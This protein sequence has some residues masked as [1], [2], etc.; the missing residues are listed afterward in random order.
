MDINH[1]LLEFAKIIG[2]DDC[3]SHDQQSTR[4]EAR[5]YTGLQRN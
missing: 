4:N 2:H 5:D 3:R 1:D